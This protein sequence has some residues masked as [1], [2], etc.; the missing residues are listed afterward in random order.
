MDSQ[1]RTVKHMPV[2]IGLRKDPDN[3]NQWIPFYGHT[4]GALSVGT[5]VEVHFG[6]E[7]IKRGV[8]ESSEICKGCM[9]FSVPNGTAFRC[10]VSTTPIS[11]GY[12][13]LILKDISDIMEEL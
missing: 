2:V 9:F 7:C 1:N 8:I 3:K 10:A 4:R 13:D 5:I 6:K 12:N 11:C